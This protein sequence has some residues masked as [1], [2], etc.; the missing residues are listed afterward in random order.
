MPSVDQFDEP[1]AVDVRIDLGR[2]N[3]GMPQKRLDDAKVRSA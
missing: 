3:I 2:G 1:A